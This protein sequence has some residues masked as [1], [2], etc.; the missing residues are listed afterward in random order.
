MHGCGL[1]LPPKGYSVWA[2]QCQSR[3]GQHLNTGTRASRGSRQKDTSATSCL[4]VH[5]GLCAFAYER[6]KGCGCSCDLVQALS[7]TLPGEYSSLSSLE[8][9]KVSGHNL[10]G[11]LPAG[12]AEGMAALAVLDLSG[13]KLQGTLP[14]QWLHAGRL[15]PSISKQHWT[16]TL[17]HLDLGRNQLTGQLPINLSGLT[18]LRVLDLNANHL[19]AEPASATP[20]LLVLNLKFQRVDPRTV[21]AVHAAALQQFAVPAC[22]R[23]SAKQLASN[24]TG[25]SPGHSWQLCQAAEAAAAAA[26]L[27]RLS[28][29]GSV[30]PALLTIK[31]LDLAG[32]ALS[33]PLPPPVSGPLGHVSN[34]LN[35]NGPKPK[36]YA[37]LQEEPS[38]PVE[39]LL[40][41]VDDDIFKWDEQIAAGLDFLSRDD[42]TLTSMVTAFHGRYLDLLDDDDDDVAM[43]VFGNSTAVEGQAI[44]VAEPT[45]QPPLCRPVH[46]L[47]GLDH[48]TTP[49]GTSLVGQKHQVNPNAAQPG[50]LNYQAERAALWELWN[51]AVGVD[52]PT[53]PNSE[54]AG[55][56]AAGVGAANSSPHP[57]LSGSTA[58]QLPVTRTAVL[59]TSDLCR[60]WESQASRQL[61]AAG[62]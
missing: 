9:L 49:F 41:Y 7:G 36:Q 2:G 27:K 37:G 47:Y 22:G 30:P 14:K 11:T 13:N 29:H 28:I 23:S 57:V 8:I 53:Y 6:F 56:A 26:A 39:Q 42:E 33:G 44:Q 38:P 32:L 25:A 1:G 45:V 48:S 35:Q 15:H 24:A 50:W 12:W 61:A 16:S 21:K 43:S 5:R 60:A 55:P 18:A 40:P 58:P 34:G 62:G 4:E 10:S 59:E 19:S 3:I 20:K 52:K 51:E 46:A 31:K 54:T 17:A